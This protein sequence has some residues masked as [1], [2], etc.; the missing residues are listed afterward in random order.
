METIHTT[1]ASLKQQREMFDGLG[2]IYEMDSTVV[3]R[4]KQIKGVETYLFTPNHAVT[5]KLLLYFH[6]GC[7]ALG[8]ID[9]HR[10]MLTHFATHLQ[11]TILYVE[12]GLAPEKPYP[13][14]VNDGLTVYREVIGGDQEVILMGDSA[15][16]GIVLSL[17]GDL[18]KLDIAQPEGVVLL[19]PW[20]DLKCDNTSYLTNAESDPIISKTNLEPYAHIYAGENDL[21]EIN[22]I[23]QPFKTF[24]KNLI[25]VSESEVLFD[26]SNLLHG[27]VKEI[28]PES[29][30]S[31]FSGQ[32]HVWPLTD[33]NSEASQRAMKE[34]KGFLEGLGK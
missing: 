11:T 25:L 34:I 29:G 23:D 20:L 17:L 5:G 2:K 32:S 15:G 28:Q 10:A 30:L 1:I 33:I 16:G 7:Y 13:F 8:S 31:V 18:Q 21:K 19:S 4:Q 27:K 6:G 14:G 26:D 3:I 12:Y 24:P 22:P 9:S